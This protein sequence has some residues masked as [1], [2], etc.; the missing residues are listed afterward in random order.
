MPAGDP[1]AAIHSPQ[2]LSGDPPAAAPVVPN[3]ALSPAR[4]PEGR[5]TPRAGE[6][7][8]LHYGGSGSSTASTQQ[9][10]KTEE[11]RRGKAVAHGE[12]EIFHRKDYEEGRSQLRQDSADLSR[13]VS[14]KEALVGNRTFKPRFDS[15]RKPDEWR[16]NEPRSHPTR[17]TVWRRLGPRQES[18]HDRLGGRVRK[19]PLDINGFHLLLKKKAV[20]RCYNCLASDHRIAACRDPPRCILCSRSG[21]KARLCPGRSQSQRAPTTAWRR[22]VPEAREGIENTAGVAPAAAAAP[23]TVSPPMDFIPGV[24]SRRP[25]RVA[26][27]AARSSAVREAER[28]LLLRGL[29]A[30]QRDAR[31]RLTCDVVLREA[32]HQLCIPEHTIQV[33]RISTASFLLRFET[34]ELRNTARA[35]GTLEVGSSSLHLMSWGRQ[36]GAFD[37][38]LAYRARV[39]L[40]GVPY[41]AHQVDS[42]LHLLPKRSFVEGIDYVKTREDEKGCFILWIWCKDPDEIGVQGTLEIEEH[43]VLP[44]GYQYCVEDAQFPIVRSD[45]MPMLKYDVLIH[46][47]CVEDYSPLSNRPSPMRYPFVWHLGQPDVLPD[48]PRASVHSRLGGRK[49]R[50]P[51]RGGGSGNGKMLQ[52]PTPNQFDTPRPNFESAGTSTFRGNAGGGFH[53]RQQGQGYNKQDTQVARDNFSHEMAMLQ[54]TCLDSGFSGGLLKSMDPMLEEFAQL[55]QEDV[56]LE[57]VDKNPSQGSVALVQQ[58][59]EVQ[60]FVS[61]SQLP[62][63]EVRTASMPIPVEGELSERQQPMPDPE[64]RMAPLPIPVDG[65][66]SERQHE[67]AHSFDLNLLFD[68]SGEHTPISTSTNQ[69]VPAPVQCAEVVGD[70]QPDNGTPLVELL[71][72]RSVDAPESSR[73]RNT[74]RGVACFAIPLKKAL[75]CNPSLRPRTLHLKKKTNMEA[76]ALAATAGQNGGKRQAQGSIEEQAAALLIRKSGQLGEREQIQ[77][78]DHQKFGE[79]FVHPMQED[80]LG[81]MRNTFGLPEYGG[82]DCLGALAIDAEV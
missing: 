4:T 27:C 44:E 53:Y 7:L 11:I 50:S 34:P 2:T 22:R 32:L 15:S 37:G 54:G 78:G 47:D 6:A 31:A 43:A 25:A 46:L 36:A 76:S 60:Q 28:D 38:S 71:D 29:I 55:V 18:I 65:E 41:H 61:E 23:A 73:H 10:S 20:G 24:P 79:Q 77:E 33:T 40:E 64:V 21:H 12:G 82:M 48:P 74:A 30:V 72:K 14:Y 19:E 45:V 57:K 75:L 52:R 42:V 67:F 16:E 68:V 59:T 70:A 35:R 49:D 80:L 1:P 39:C 9:D 58:S 3:P 62:G 8:D 26:A 5:H 51:P 63:E 13:R 66:L 81:S 17:S 69:V 56:G